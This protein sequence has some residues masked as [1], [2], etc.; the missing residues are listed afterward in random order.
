MPLLLIQIDKNFLNM[1]LYEDNQI[2][3][4]PYFNIN[5]FI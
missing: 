1:N 4:S 2:V 3:F 5:F